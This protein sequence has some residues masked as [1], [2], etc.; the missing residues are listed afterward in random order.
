MNKTGT[1]IELPVVLAIGFIFATPHISAY[2]IESA[3]DNRDGEV[4]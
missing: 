2:Q 3:A 1:G 4:L